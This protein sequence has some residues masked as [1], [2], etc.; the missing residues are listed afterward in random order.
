MFGIRREKAE[1]PLQAATLTFSSP[2]DAAILEKHWSEGIRRGGW[3]IV[4]PL[5]KKY[6]REHA[7]WSGTDVALYLPVAAEWPEGTRSS[8]P[9]LPR[10]P[11]PSLSA[12]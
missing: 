4:Q 11:G 9:P 3:T 12:I 5:E 8:R 7:Y 2:L 10:P 6:I 1:P